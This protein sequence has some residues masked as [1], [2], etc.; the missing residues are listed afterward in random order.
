MRTDVGAG[1]SPEEFKVTWQGCHLERKVPSV[2]W[3]VSTLLLSSTDCKY[4]RGKQPDVISAQSASS[5][6]IVAKSPR[7]LKP[8][9]KTRSH[10]WTYTNTL[11]YTFQPASVMIPVERAFIVCLIM[12]QDK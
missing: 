9:L 7:I 10:T 11:A 4:A 2:A 5:L 3:N 6:G 1:L 12:V 8:H